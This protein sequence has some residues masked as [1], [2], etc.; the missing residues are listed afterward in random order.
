MPNWRLPWLGLTRLCRC[1]SH[2]P[3]VSFVK[4]QLK[5]PGYLRYMDDMALFSDDRET[6]L[7]AR[8]QIAEWLQQ[9]RH[10][11]LNPKRWDVLPNTAAGVFLG[12]RVSRAGISPSRKLRRSLVGRLRLAARRGYTPLVRCIRAYR[13]LLLF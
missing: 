3:L 9:A 4:R 1:L 5:I 12:Y 8:Q 6:L 11:Q 2:E 7:L 13:G 10:L